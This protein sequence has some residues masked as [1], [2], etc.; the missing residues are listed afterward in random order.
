MFE[1]E[2]H[3]HTSL[4]RLIATPYPAEYRTAA[5]NAIEVCLRL[6]PEEKFILI[7]DEASLAIGA[8]LADEVRSLGNPMHVF[9][10]EEMGVR[11]MIAMPQEILDALF[12]TDVS[13]YACASQAGE[14]RHRIEMMNTINVAKPR[15]G[16]MVNINHRIMIEG[17]QADFIEVDR[18][19]QRVFELA[20]QARTI[21]AKTRHGTDIEAILSPQLNWLKTSGIISSDKWGNLP[22]GE[23]FTAPENVNG[24]YVVDGVVGDYLCGKYGELSETPLTIEIANS[25]I[26]SCSCE[27]KELLHEFI[28]YCMTDENSNR[29]GEFAIGTNTACTSIIGHILQDE[30]LPGVHIAFGHPYAEH[31]GADWKSSTH[32][33][34]VGRDFDIW[35]EGQKIMQDG[36]FMKD[37]LS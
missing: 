22:G 7:T 10:L 37:I 31:T 25:R 30:K 13:I 36:M 2:R 20:S 27:N 32:I 24:V 5:R 34:V 4:E 11:P 33:D 17:M 14:L 35:I 8:S 9:I 26:R 3:A 1:G 29:V 21:T 16:H 28:Q 23:T 15:H 6:Q 19:S 18:I 12:H